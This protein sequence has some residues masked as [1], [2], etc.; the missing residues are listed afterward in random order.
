MKLE[1][2]SK[3]IWITDEP[4]APHT[5]GTAPGML[6][7]GLIMLNTGYVMV[8][9]GRRFLIPA[10]CVYQIDGHKLHSTEGSGALAVLIWDMPDWSLANFRRELKQDVRFKHVKHFPAAKSV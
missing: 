1:Q 8:Y 9:D 6:T 10:G 4:V 7:Y 5:D 2:V 3:D